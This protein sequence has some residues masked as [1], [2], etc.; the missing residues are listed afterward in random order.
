MERF[1]LLENQFE[2]LPVIEPLQL[3]ASITKAVSI[4]CLRL[5][6]VHPFISGNKWF[7]L[8]HYLFAA[9]QQEKT[10]L[11]SFGGAYSNH[12]H[13]LAYVGKLMS[14][15][16]VGIV[17]GEAPKELSPTLQDCKT[18]GMELHWI[19]REEYRKVSRV[20][21]IDIMQTRFPDTFVIPE[22]GEGEL[23]VH[24]VQGLFSRL[25]HLVEMPYDLI[26]CPVGSGATLAGIV[27]ATAGRAQVLGFSAL[28]GATDLEQRV[29]NAF[30]AQTPQ[31]SWRI[32]HDYHFGGFA[33][34]NERLADFI[35]R[36][37]SGSG[38]L[39]DPVYTGKTLFGLLEYL[40]Q[41]RIK[42]GSRVLFV[43][44]GGL[45]GWRGMRVARPV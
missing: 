42:T 13:A 43:H 10:R 2:E 11:L 35:S 27:L 22:G 41:G 5:D 40:Q 30:G 23:G 19:G 3:D 25:Y 38:L 32:C 44:T 8:Q 28:R 45:Q 36:I 16:T 29:R 20:Q 31:G 26:V 37:H 21:H 18:W 14:L 17:R 12:L 6:Q 24:G 9:L 7:K 39:L 4:D 34:M 15:A 1:S 33:K